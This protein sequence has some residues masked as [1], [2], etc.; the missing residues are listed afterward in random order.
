MTLIPTKRTLSKRITHILFF[1]LCSSFTL[2][3]WEQ[4]PVWEAPQEYR[5]MKNPYKGL[6]DDQWTGRILFAKHCKLCHGKKGRGDG[7]GAKLLE[8][9]VANFNAPAFRKQSDGSIFYK[10]KKGRKEMP[11]FE[12]VITEDEDLWMLINYIRRL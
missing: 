7:S 6:G 12:K 1:V 2:V 10:I 8:T 9:P 3:H 4:D 11:S 5:E